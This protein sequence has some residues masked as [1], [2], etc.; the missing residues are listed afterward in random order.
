MERDLLIREARAEDLPALTDIYNH[1]VLN[2]VI[3][4]DLEPFDVKSRRPWFEQFA[5]TGPYRL[6]VGESDGAVV[7]Y[8]C[9][10][11]FR[12]K[13][14]YNR[15]VESSVYLDPACEGRG[16]GTQLYE[17]LFEALASEPVHR[18]YAAMALPN[19]ASRALH[20]KV[21]FEA[22]HVMNEVGFKFGRYVD[23]EWFEKKLN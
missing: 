4:F 1:Y 9:S 16:F 20:F 8:A 5:D 10:T 15:S 3:T 22:L 19:D 7:G 21:G 13:P 23:T 17:A 2:T 18:V 12:P 6:L 11:R 14:A